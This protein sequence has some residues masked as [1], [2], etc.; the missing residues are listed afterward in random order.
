MVQIAKFV[1]YH[2]PTPA[3]TY[4]TPRIF[5]AHILFIHFLFKKHSYLHPSLLFIITTHTPPPYSQQ[6]SPTLLS[7]PYTP[8]YTHSVH[9]M[10]LPSTDTFRT[11]FVLS[12]SFGEISNN[13]VRSNGKYVQCEG[14]GGSE[15]GVFLRADDV[16]RRLCGTRLLMIRGLNLYQTSVSCFIALIHDRLPQSSF[17][18]TGY[19]ACTGSTSTLRVIQPKHSASPSSHHC[20]IFYLR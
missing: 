20:L 3:H 6:P 16:K 9:S 5:H 11:D 13:F 12:F 15:C 8:T 4:G 19:L 18:S 10:P 17:W 7:Q 14:G 2:L 1:K